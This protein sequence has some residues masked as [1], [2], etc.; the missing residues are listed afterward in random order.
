MLDILHEDDALL[1]VNKPA[2]LVCHPTKGD[3]WSSLVSRLRIHRGGEPV[4]LVNR[5]DRET[6]GVVVAAKSSEAARELGRLFESRA[7]RKEY[8]AVVH[9]H[10]GPGAFT[11]AAP[12]GRDEQSEVAIKDTVRADGAAAVTEVETLRRFTRPEGEF[13]LVRAFPHSGRKHQIRIHLAHAGHPVVGDKIYGGD[14]GRYLRFV[15]GQL[16]AADR[17]VLLLEH[18]ALHA[19][20]LSFHWR[21]RDWVFRSPPEPWFA[22]FADGGTRSMEAEGVPG[23]GADGGEP[24]NSG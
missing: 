4:S 6:G 14:P 16:T 3:A 12:L 22:A 18:H 23:E 10:T 24:R 21:D 15:G 8:A 9:G 1:V 2:G 5:L 13:S 11:V 19:V 17:A 20:V 7:V